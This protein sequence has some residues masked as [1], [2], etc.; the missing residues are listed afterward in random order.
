VVLRGIGGADLQRLSDV[1]G[2]LAQA[3]F[4]RLVLVE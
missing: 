3:G 2:L 4:S 1:A